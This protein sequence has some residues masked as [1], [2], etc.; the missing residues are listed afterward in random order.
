LP[1]KKKTDLH[2]LI[3]EYLGISCLAAVI[4]LTALQVFM[5]YV[6]RIPLSWTEEIIR[7]FS[8]WMIFLGSIVAVN[9]KAHVS[10]DYF[11]NLFPVKAKRVF[12]LITNIL[13]VFFFAF[14]LLT[15]YTLVVEMKGTNSAASGYPVPLLYL[16]ILIGAAGMLLEAVI[17]TIR[18]LTGWKNYGKTEDNPE[19]GVA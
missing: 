13:M 18:L 11:V 14:L 10:V 16:A 2:I 19:G 4:L 7:L 6:V 17:Q 15:S 9:K 8:A 3:A 12:Q 5:R 1:N